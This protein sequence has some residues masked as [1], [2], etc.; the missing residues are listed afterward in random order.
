V[1]QKLHNLG[2]AY[3]IF[4]GLCSVI[5]SEQIHLDAWDVREFLGQPL[6]TADDGIFDESFAE[7]IHKQMA[8]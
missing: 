8:Q 7:L 5:M 2:D 4:Q 1:T 3:P 6:E